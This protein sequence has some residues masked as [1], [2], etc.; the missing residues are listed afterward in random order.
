MIKKMWI[1]LIL[2]GIF[3]VELFNSVLRVVKLA[4]ILDEDED[5]EMD[6]HVQAMMYI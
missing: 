6:P 5:E 2:T 3:I 4:Y 1:E